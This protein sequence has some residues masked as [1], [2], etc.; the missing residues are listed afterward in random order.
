[1]D[2]KLQE[3]II[4]AYGNGPYNR[5]QKEAIFRARVEHIRAETI[6][7][8]TST[9]SMDVTT[10]SASSTD[11]TKTPTNYATM[12]STLEKLLQDKNFHAYGNGPYN[13]K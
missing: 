3:S 11:S 9:S 8:E 7:I 6:I 10:Q 2:M 4:H 1:M 12:R 5:K 13:Q